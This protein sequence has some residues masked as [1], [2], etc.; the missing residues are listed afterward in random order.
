MWAISEGLRQENPDIRVTTISAGVVV[1]ELGDDEGR[2]EVSQTGL[3]RR[4]PRSRPTTF[5]TALIFHR[6]AT[7][8]L[9]W[10]GAPGPR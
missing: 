9:I 4:D 2:D 3:H 1:T 8:S 6:D 7:A 5:N 10:S